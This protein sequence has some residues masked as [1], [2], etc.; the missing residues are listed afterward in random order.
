[1][2]GQARDDGRVTLRRVPPGQPAARAGLEVGDE[3]VAIDG[4]DV[5]RMSP[6]A[7]HDA[8]EGECGTTVSLTVLRQGRVDRVPVVRAP[9]QG[10]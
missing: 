5:R 6:Q 1:V 10:P 8:L 9:F 4:R 2:L 3:V 7:V